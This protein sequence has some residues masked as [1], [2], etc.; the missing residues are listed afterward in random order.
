[1]S[2]HLLAVFA[3]GMLAM[4]AGCHAV[5]FYPSSLQSPIPPEL[6]PPRELSMVSLPAYR[7]A[8]PDVIRI[9]AVKMVPLTS[10]RISPFDILLIRALGTLR[11]QP[12]AKQYPVEANGTVILGGPYGTVRLAGYTVEEAEAEVTR[13]LKMILE[14]PFVSI[15]LMR[16]A[17]AEQINGVYPVQADGR[18]NLGTCGMAYVAGKT[19]TEAREAVQTSL[20]QY[21]DSPTVGVE[22]LQFNSK[23]YFVIAE[24]TAGGGA[25][26]RFPIT[27]NETVLDG[28]AQL[29][30]IGKMTGKMIWLARPAPGNCGTTQVLPVNWDE[31]AHGG[32][33]D[34]NYQLLPGDRIY[35]VEDKGSGVNA[36]VAKLASP[37]ERLLGLTSRGVAEAR[38]AETLGRE[39]NARGVSRF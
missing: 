22:V 32:R 15:Q 6:A 35:I 17:A 11:N 16:S 38:D 28:I 33:V 2:K 21:F 26:H 3:I 4:A 8:P 10:Y 24:S 31:I 23:S 1:M 7:I 5:D 37:I 34:T 14:R 13:S 27:G 18:V 20:N 36:F 25:L 30:R 12:I 39:Y 29:N 19:V 9:Q